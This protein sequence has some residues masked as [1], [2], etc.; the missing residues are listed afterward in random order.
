MASKIKRPK[1]K[2]TAATMTIHGPGKMSN[3]ERVDLLAWL[4]N[5]VAL[6]KSRHLTVGRYRA[7]LRYY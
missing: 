3:K 5:Q 6:V 1:I 4:S 7:G 2:K